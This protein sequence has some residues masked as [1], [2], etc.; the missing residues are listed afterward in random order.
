MNLLAPFV[1]ETVHDA[2][3]IM[4]DGQNDRLTY[5]AC[6]GVLRNAGLRRVARKN[7]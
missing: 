4:F 2:V 5:G 3:E 7:P 1:P 6:Q